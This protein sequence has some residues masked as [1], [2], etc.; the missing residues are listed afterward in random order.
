MIYTFKMYSRK[1]N[2][3]VYE[4]EGSLHLTSIPRESEYILYKENIHRAEFV[5]HIPSEYD[6]HEIRIYCVI[7]QP[8]NADNK[9]INGSI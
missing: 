8:I 5:Y 2:E 9:L 4:Y 6:I 7:T 1:E 3:D